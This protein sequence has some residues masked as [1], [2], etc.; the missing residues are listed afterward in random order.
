MPGRL[1]GVSMLVRWLLVISAAAGAMVLWLQPEDVQFFE[2]ALNAP[3]YHYHM[4]SPSCRAFA[5]K[6]DG[7]N[8]PTQALLTAKHCVDH[9]KPGDDLTV[10][11]SVGGKSLTTC[12]AGMKGDAD[13]ALLKL[14]IADA[15]SNGYLLRTSPIATNGLRV[16][17]LKNN[18]GTDQRA[19]GL[20]RT[21]TA[22]RSFEVEPDTAGDNLIKSDSGGPGAIAR[23]AAGVISN[24]LSNGR[25]EFTSIPAAADWIATTWASNVCH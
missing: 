3:G 13:L 8:N 21:S 1:R 12:I 19:Q 10:M 15:S 11:R 20:N 23:L 22:G 17:Y 7:A 6:L 25:Y 18:A 9:K 14:R 4:V 2:T 16:M 24:S 5:V